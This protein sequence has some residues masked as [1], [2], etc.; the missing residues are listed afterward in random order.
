MARLTNQEVPESDLGSEPVLSLA[1]LQLLASEL[2]V[3]PGVLHERCLVIRSEK[4]AWPGF[5]MSNPE[6]VWDDS[7][8]LLLA[9]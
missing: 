6:R 4:P 5:S 1:G 9:P 7:K 3:D 2:E 8:R